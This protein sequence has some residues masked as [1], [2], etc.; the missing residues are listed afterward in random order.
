MILVEAPP[1]QGTP[2]RDPLGCSFE[3]SAGA[4][5]RDL[6]KCGCASTWPR[7]AGRG[8]SGYRQC[9]SASSRRTRHAPL[10]PLRPPSTSRGG[11]L[12]GLPEAACQPPRC[13]LGA[14]RLPAAFDDATGHLVLG[15]GPRKKIRF[16]LHMLCTCACH[17]AHASCSREWFACGLRPA[18]GSLRAGGVSVTCR[19][20]N[21][22]K[23]PSSTL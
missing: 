15:R 3:V 10:S 7:L 18:A 16:A 2:P 20:N 17:V 11:A 1:T 21:T 6:E 4:A 13:A 14:L 8:D 23:S 19:C 12:R 5:P 22:I 9:H